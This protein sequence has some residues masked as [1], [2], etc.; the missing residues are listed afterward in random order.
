MTIETVAGLTDLQIRFF[1]AIGQTL[2]ALA[3]GTIA[4]LIAWRQWKTA[5]QQAKTARNKLRLDLYERRL[6]VFKE[7]H[8][9]TIEALSHTGAGKETN[10]IG[11]MAEVR[12]LFGEKV[13]E[14]ISERLYAELVDL[15]EARETRRMLGNMRPFEG[16]AR[17]EY[18]EA[19]AT[20]SRLRKSVYKNLKEFRS[21][22]DSYLVL[23]H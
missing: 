7:L 22:M 21:I 17:L 13:D 16:A 18:E 23:E 5:E 3:V 20:S 12:Y 19:V 9:A 4:A 10:L 6:A 14:F 15:T 8:Q 2:V 1:T 11:A